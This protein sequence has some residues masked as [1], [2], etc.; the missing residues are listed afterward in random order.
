MKTILRIRLNKKK[1]LFNRGHIFE[2]VEINESYPRYLQE[3]KKKYRE[4]II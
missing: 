3:N 4:W 1:D 2:Q